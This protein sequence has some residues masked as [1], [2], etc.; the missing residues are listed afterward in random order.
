[1]LKRANLIAAGRAIAMLTVMAALSR[2]VAD[3]PSGSTEFRRDIRPILETYC[4]DCHGDGA[5]KGNVAFDELKTDQAVLT[6]RDL[7]WKALKNVRAGMMPPAKK[8]RTSHGR[9]A[10]SPHPMDQKRGFSWRPGQS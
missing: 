7:W 1:M 8:P 2:A 6:N 5:H 9:P 3:A 4:F 10:T